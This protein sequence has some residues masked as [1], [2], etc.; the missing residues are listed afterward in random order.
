MRVRKAVP[1]GYKTSATTS[2]L[3]GYTRRAI[4]GP[5]ATTT[6]STTTTTT[7]AELL[8]FC[9]MFKVGN[10]AVQTYT[11]GDDDDD[12]F[13]PS[14][15]E[16][17]ASS[18]ALPNPHKRG[19]QVDV[20]SDIEDTMTTTMFPG[21]GQSSLR[22]I[23]TPRLG[24]RNRQART[25]DSAKASRF[26]HVGDSSGYWGQENQAPTSHHFADFEDAAFLR[27]REEVDDEFGMMM[28][29]E[30]EMGGV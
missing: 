5:A 4:Y 12:G 18:I 20:D 26:Q 25:H 19:L 9:G 14:S 30:V 17:T 3:D 8:P 2:K 27:R 23:L 21:G 7:A 15:Q 16:S 6:T 22:P 11:P 13:L 28:I 10:L 29:R 1:E 24:Q